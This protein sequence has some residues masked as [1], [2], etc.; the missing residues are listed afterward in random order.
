MCVYNYRIQFIYAL[1]VCCAIV[2]SFIRQYFDYDYASSAES[3]ASTA[4]H[5]RENEFD[6]YSN[7][8]SSSEEDLQKEPTASIEMNSNETPSNA[9]KPEG[10]DSDAGNGS[11]TNPSGGAG[12]DGDGGGD[13]AE[14]SENANSAEP[15]DQGGQ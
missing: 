11:G 6:T 15:S 9:E 1:C 10:N 13:S 8:P 4:A 12:G 2:K 3:I 7:N 14:S 5:D